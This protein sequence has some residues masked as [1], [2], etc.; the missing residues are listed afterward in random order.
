MFENV[1][2]NLDISIFEESIC[3]I[4]QFDKCLTRRASFNLIHG[5]LFSSTSMTVSM[6]LVIRFILL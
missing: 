2:I 1:M 3:C 5:H 6:Q 4:L